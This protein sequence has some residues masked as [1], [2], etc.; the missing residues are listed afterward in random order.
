MLWSGLLS[1]LS[2]TN[3]LDRPLWKVSRAS[4][5]YASADEKQWYSRCCYHTFLSHMSG[6]PDMLCVAKMIERIRTLDPPCPTTHLISIGGWNA[7]HPDTAHT[8]GDTYK[9]WHKWNTQTI[10]SEKHGFYGNNWI[11][12]VISSGW[13]FTDFYS[14]DGKTQSACDI[15][16]TDSLSFSLSLS[17]SFSPLLP[18]APKVLMGLTGI[19]RA[20]T[21]RH[22][23]ITDLP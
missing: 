3:L 1:I 21:M 18:F 6:G 9:A 13:T 11:F 7:P 10:I 19:L 22:R 8:A 5:F 2:L 23:F 16:G 12:Y 17:F 4:M 14:W 15:R 20:M